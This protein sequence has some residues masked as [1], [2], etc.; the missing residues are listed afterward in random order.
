MDAQWWMVAGVAVGLV[1]Q[2]ITL[3]VCLRIRVAQLESE[4]KV[5]DEVEEKYVRK[6][7]CPQVR[8]CEMVGAGGD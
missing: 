4:K 5:L 6:E 3:A 1:G 2:L 7:M 8:N